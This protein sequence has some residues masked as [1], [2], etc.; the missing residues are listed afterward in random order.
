MNITDQAQETRQYVRRFF[1]GI[2]AAGADLW[3]F[4][5]AAQR[6]VR[7]AG[8]DPEPARRHVTCAYHEV[9]EDRGDASQ[10]R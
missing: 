6:P 2:A 4:C 3:G 8:R 5:G 7:P 1:V 10:L 9:P